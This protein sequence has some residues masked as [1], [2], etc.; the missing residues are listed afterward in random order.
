MNVL[1]TINMTNS[2]F[3][4]VQEPQTFLQSFNGISSN[5]SL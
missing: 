3:D 5:V 2:T 1:I 4:S